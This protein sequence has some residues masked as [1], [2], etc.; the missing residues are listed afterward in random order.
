MRIFKNKWFAKFAKREGITDIKLRE[1]I[2]DVERGKID[3]NYGGDVIKQRIARVNEGKSGGYRSVILYQKNNKAFFVYG[4][5][6]SERENIDEDEE[7]E[8]K[9]LAKLTFSLSDDN[10][11]KLI[12]Q[13]AYTELK[14]DDQEE[15]L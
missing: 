3:V 2:A 5:A 13:G 6:K 7:R 10:L 14:D 12:Q 9:E 4:F 15:N 1:V 8:F 11:A